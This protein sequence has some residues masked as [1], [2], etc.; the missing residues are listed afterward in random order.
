MAEFR[1]KHKPGAE[2]E[3]EKARFFGLGFGDDA[4]EKTIRGTVIGCISE[5]PEM[6]QKDLVLMVAEKLGEGFS[7]S[8]IRDI[9]IELAKR[10][11]PKI[12]EVKTGDRGAK[13]YSLAEKPN[14][15]VD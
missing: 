8:R 5:H 9:L 2:M 7:R 11:D 10:K 1:Y 15:K 3:L 13:L 4:N 6:N 12:L 14:P